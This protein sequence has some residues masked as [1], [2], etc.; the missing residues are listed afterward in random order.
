MTSTNTDGQPTKRHIRKALREASN[1]HHR[2]QRDL[3]SVKPPEQRA[4]LVRS[5]ASACEDMAY[6][7]GLRQLPHGVIRDLTRESWIL[8][9]LAAA[10]D[11]RARHARLDPEHR[12]HR[13]PVRWGDVEQRYGM[14]LDRIAQ[15]AESH[16]VANAYLEFGHRV[17]IDDTTGDHT[18][19]TITRL[20]EQYARRT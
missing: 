10:E 18:A 19:A 14:W 5:L 11:C 17:L 9:G 3:D 7:A 16:R 15:P 12:G 13:A 6:W 8:L 4:D 2:I 1:R 20:T